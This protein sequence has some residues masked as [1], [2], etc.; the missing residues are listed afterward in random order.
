MYFMARSH[1]ET[2]TGQIFNVT[3][4]TVRVREREKEN[5]VVDPTVQGT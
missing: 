3:G 5:R 1:E 4:F 2:P